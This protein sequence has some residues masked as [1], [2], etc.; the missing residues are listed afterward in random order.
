MRGGWKNGFCFIYFSCGFE[1]DFRENIITIP[2]TD[3]IPT[4]KHSLDNLKCETCYALTDF[5]Y[6]TYSPTHVTEHFTIEGNLRAK[7][8]PGRGQIRSLRST[9]DR[10][11]QKQNVSGLCREVSIVISSGSRIVECVRF[12]RVLFPASVPKHIHTSR[13]LSC[14]ASKINGLIESG[15]DFRMCDRQGMELLPNLLAGLITISNE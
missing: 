5:C 13:I 15:Y 11:P 6:C 10:K 4:A 14:S 3:V 2:I 8:K 7:S 1:T 9:I 12:Q